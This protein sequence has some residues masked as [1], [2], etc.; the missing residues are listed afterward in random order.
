MDENLRMQ[1][2]DEARKAVAKAAIDGEKR[3]REAAISEFEAVEYN[4]KQRIKELEAAAVSSRGS[5]GTD[6]LSIESFNKMLTKKSK[7]FLSG[8][9]SKVQ[10]CIGK[11]ETFTKDEVLKVLKPI[12]IGEMDSLDVV[13][14]E[15]AQASSPATSGIKRAVTTHDAKCQTDFVN[16][17]NSRPHSA[18]EELSGSVA[19]RPSITGPPPA[20]FLWPDSPTTEQ[21]GEG[22][23]GSYVTYSILTN[24]APTD[25]LMKVSTRRDLASFGKSGQSV[26]C[27][28]RFSE[29][30]TLREA[31]LNHLPKHSLVVVPNLP[32]QKLGERL[33]SADSLVHKRRVRLGLWLQ[34]ISGHPILAYA[35]PLSVFCCATLSA[36][37]SCWRNAIDSAGTQGEGSLIDANMKRGAID[38]NLTQNQQKALGARLVASV[39]KET[40]EEV[41]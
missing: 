41:Y 2:R 33:Q 7:L 12:L 21:H 11:G 36:V 13:L 8:L 31:L 10:G 22:V 18:G 16:D 40:M 30:V 14:H 32:K 37:P 20:L 25:S 34:H 24:I 3:G 23:F 35:R 6:N 4:L 28:R 9:Y 29:F 15:V 19:Y 1:W 27:S 17:F 39:I 5:N 38:V 26:K